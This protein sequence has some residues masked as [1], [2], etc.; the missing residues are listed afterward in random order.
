MVLLFLITLAFV[1]ETQA[2]LIML[3]AV[4]IFIFLVPKILLDF[5]AIQLS[6]THVVSNHRRRKFSSISYTSVFLQYEKYKEMSSM[7]SYGGDIGMVSKRN[8]KTKSRQKEK[9]KGINM[10]IYLPD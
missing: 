5:H 9:T 6:A 3:L 8:L 10:Y 1:F 7:T 4:I 2:K